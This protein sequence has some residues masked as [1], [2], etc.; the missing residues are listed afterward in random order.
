[1]SIINNDI[2]VFQFETAHE[3]DR[4]KFYLFLKNVFIEVMQIDIVRSFNSV[5]TNL[6]II[7]SPTTYCH[8]Y[9]HSLVDPKSFRL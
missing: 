3:I 9:F 7:P 5:I 2:I 1:M 6:N 4:K 8:K